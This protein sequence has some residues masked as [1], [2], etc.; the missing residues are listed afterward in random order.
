MAVMGRISNISRGSLHDGPGVRTVVY[1]KGCGLHCRWCHNPETF[2]SR[3]EIMFAPTKCI[4]CGRCIEVC[5]E[6]HRIEGN[7]MVF[8][9]EGCMGCGKCAENCPSGALSLCGEKKT[10]EEVFREIKKDIHFFKVSGGGVTLSGGE[11]LLQ[12]EFAASLLEQC[13]KEQIH[14]VIESAFFVPWENAE[15]VL[16]LVD[17]VYADL[18]IADS[19]KHHQYT[20]QGNELILENIKK[21]SALHIPLILRIP[22]IPGVNDSRE[23]MLA[24][25]EII[26]TFSSGV[27]G[28][29]LLRYNFLGESK[30]Q[31]LGKVYESFGQE[32]QGKERLE[33]LKEC[34][35]NGILKRCQVFFRV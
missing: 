31:S 20:G 13:R 33:E 27:Q 29:E 21:L 11:C 6:Q 2:S 18:K 5:P 23:D 4:H 8:D 14:T 9:R 1:L 16:P 24:F 3:A 32:A 34:L 26:K 7:D 30:Y 10:V 35:E 25:A 28:V 17:L 15:K 12:P 19:K 22:L